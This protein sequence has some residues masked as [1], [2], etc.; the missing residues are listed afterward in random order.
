MKEQY[1]QQ[2]IDM[3]TKA[4]WMELETVTNYLVNS[5]DLDG[6]RATGLPGAIERRYATL[7]CTATQR[8]R[9]K[10]ALLS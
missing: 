8:Y 6:V 10:N 3:L 2:I 4:Y 9:I 5:V 1:R 7:H